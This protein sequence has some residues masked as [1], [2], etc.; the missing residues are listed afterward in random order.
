MQNNATAQE[1]VDAVVAFGERA[2]AA[3]HGDVRPRKPPHRVKFSWPPHPVSYEFHVPASEWRGQTTFTA[4][5]E[6]FDVKVARTPHGVFG[7]CEALWHEDRGDDEAEMLRNLRASSEP[8]FRRQLLINSALEEPG[9]FTGHIPDLDAVSLLKLLYCDDRD[10]S[11]EAM[12][13]IE[14]HA[15]SSLFFPALLAV[16]RDRKHPN[17]RSAQWCV[18]DL[19]EDLPSFA[20]TDSECH[21]AVESIVAIMWDAEDDFARTVFKAGV[22]L[23][24]HIPPALG[25]PALLRCLKAPSR[26]G[27]RSAIH[28]LFHVVEWFPEMRFEVV[29]ALNESAKTDP[30]PMLAEFAT[31]MARDIQFQ[32][33]DHIQEPTFPDEP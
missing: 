2:L 32:N 12:L 33:W 19:F 20:K 23:G 15:S 27:R 13:Q 22:V 25:A 18:L 6:T 28:G 5:G 8:L 10:V 26:M 29:S 7:R 11:Y 1:L 24:G 14:A 4:Y 9:R 21:E 30:E 31:L 17:R 3:N 16:L